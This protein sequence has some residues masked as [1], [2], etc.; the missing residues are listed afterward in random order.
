MTMDE[1]RYS[2]L[3]F[4]KMAGVGGLVFASGLPGCASYGTPASRQRDFSFVQLSDI[5]WGYANPKV[6][7]DFKSSFGKA[8]A[9][10]N[11]L[12]QQPDFVVFTGDLTQTT[13]DPKLRRARL[14]QFRDIA[15]RLRFAKVY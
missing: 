12:E 8:I 13:D 11:A 4:M 9:T 14:A 7:P 15:G 2:R 6:N 5:H 3:Y 1:R 10:V